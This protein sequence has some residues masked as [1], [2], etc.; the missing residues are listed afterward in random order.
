MTQFNETLH[1]VTVSGADDNTSIEQMID[2]SNKWK[3]QTIEFAILLM[4]GP[5][6]ERYPS[7]DW[8]KRLY[9]AHSENKNMLVSGHICGKWAREICDGNWNNVL[10]QFGEM[11]HMF[12]RVQ[13]NFSPYVADTN[14]VKFLDGM[15]HLDILFLKQII[16]Q[17]KNINDPIFI[18]AKNE[19]YDVVPLFQIACV[20]M[21]VDCR[22]IML[23][24]KL[25]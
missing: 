23:K 18:A 7:M 15:N 5:S 2:L 16:F 4:D 11:F 22:L 6:K 13:L 25:S 20:V 3:Y 12:N 21:Q 1:S 19:D 24:V 14:I 10:N 9:D 17:L 8:I